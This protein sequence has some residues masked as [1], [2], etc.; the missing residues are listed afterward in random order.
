MNPSPAKHRVRFSLRA[1]LLLIALCAAI[2]GYYCYRLRLLPLEVQ[3][4]YAGMSSADAIAT[5]GNPINLDPQDP[6]PN[7]RDANGRSHYW[8]WQFDWGQ[9]DMKF[10]QN[11]R[12]CLIEYKLEEQSG[13][14]V[15]TGER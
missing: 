13:W 5:L 2:V 7:P 11:D 8:I 15:V 14:H 9:L 12:S 10:D 3:H 6:R 4:V 1:L